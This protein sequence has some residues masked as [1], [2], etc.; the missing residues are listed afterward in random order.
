MSSSLKCLLTVAIL[1][2]VACSTYAI[3]CYQCESHSNPKCGEH[4]EA[5][6]SFKFDCARLAPPRY[7]QTFLSVRNATGCMKK[8]IEGVSG[9]P[10][11]FRTCYFGDISNTQTGC[12]PDPSLPFV[13]QLACEVCTGDLCNSSS[14]AGPIGATLLLLFFMLARFLS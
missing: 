6:D 14:V 2:S 3:H 9:H 8:S 1:A 11:I 13:K 5:E 12:Q 4:F 7:L 10:Q